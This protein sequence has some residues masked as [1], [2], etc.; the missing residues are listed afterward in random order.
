MEYLLLLLKNKFLEKIKESDQL[1][2]IK[3]IRKKMMMIIIIEVEDYYN[4][5]LKI[6][7]NG[8]KKENHNLK[9]LHE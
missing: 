5:L 3:K 4:L 8:F 7:N 9:Y 6:G 2:K 1:L